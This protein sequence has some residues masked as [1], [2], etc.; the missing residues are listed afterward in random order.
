MGSPTR[1]DTNQAAQSLNTARDLKFRV[2]EEPGVCTVQVAKTETLISFAV[3]AKPIRVFVFA[4]AKFR[5]SHVAAH[6][7][8]DGHNLLIMFRWSRRIDFVFSKYRYQLV[9]ITH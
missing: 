6:L 7:I 1:P 2:K 9:E 3:T 5:L 8:V 4:Y